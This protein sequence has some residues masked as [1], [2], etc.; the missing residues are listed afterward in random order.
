[1]CGINKPNY[2]LGGLIPRKVC[3]YT[4]YIYT[5]DL[6]NVTQLCE[7]GEGNCFNV[8]ISCIRLLPHVTY[9]EPCA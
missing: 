7:K 9:E 8:A 2:T 3:T 4:I 5:N 1:M 6:S